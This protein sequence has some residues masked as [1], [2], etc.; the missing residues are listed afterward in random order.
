MIARLPSSRL[1]DRSRLALAA[2][3]GHLPT[4][5]RP[6]ADELHAT[7]VNGTRALYHDGNL[8]ASRE[9]FDRAFTAAEREQDG[10]SQALAAVGYGGLWVHEHRGAATA[11]LTELR[12]RRALNLVDD[13]SPLA[14]RLR[15]RLAA[16]ADYREGTHE[17]VFAAVEHARRLQD[18]VALAEAL[19]LAHHCVMGP[20]EAH[21]RTRLVEELIETS[22]RTGRRGDLL[23]G[24]LWRTSNLLLAADSHAERSLRELQGMLQERPHAAV[25]FI[26]QAMEVMRTIRSGDLAAAEERANACAKAGQA[27]GDI[28]SIGWFGAHMI[29]VNWYRGNLAELIPTLRELV[30]SPLLS[31]VD[32][33]HLAA[34]AVATASAGDERLARG[35]LARLAGASWSQLPMTSSWLATMYGVIEAANLLGDTKTAAAA[36]DQLRPFGHLPIMASMGIACFGS[37]EHALGVASLTMGHGDQAV[38]HLEAAVHANH[39]LQHWPAALLSRARLAEALW[40]QGEHSRAHELLNQAREE[41]EQLAMPLPRS[42]EHISRRPAADAGRAAAPVLSCERRGLRWH[43]HLGDRAAVLDAS[44]GMTYLASLIANPGF[45][46]S[47]VELAAGP[48]T[49]ADSLNGSLTTGS[50]QP[51]LDEAAKRAYKARLS[52]LDDAIA[53]YE[54][55]NDLV[56]A[57]R[58]RAERGWL[59]EELAAV[60]GLGGRTRS[61]ADAAERARISVGKAIRRAVMQATAVDPVIGDHLRSYVRTGMRCCYMPR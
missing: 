10:P 21:L 45:E 6:V 39:A 33:S 34:L 4:Q 16:E 56:R 42:T 15:A 13:D 60:T 12:L 57:E 23:I 37:A 51:V 5:P 48:G 29:A 17:R 59:I 25:G 47:A 32:N 52:Q 22:L 18:P 38:A 11:A 9:W 19:S 14:V 46:I 36:Y 28:D 50:S 44:K 2:A 61:F 31:T 27:V 26:V 40:R 35:S 30:N 20:H 1:A 54:A 53:E 3:P 7:L 49:A 8:Q 41:A 55:H 43:L 58:A 24:L